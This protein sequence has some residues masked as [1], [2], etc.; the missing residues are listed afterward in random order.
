[1]H[2]FWTKWSLAPAILRQ[3][4][5]RLRQ[6]FQ[7]KGV[8]SLGAL[9]GDALDGDVGGFAHGIYHPL[10]LGRVLD[11]EPVAL[12]IHRVRAATDFERRLR[13]RLERVAD[14]DRD[15][16][17]DLFRRTRRAESIGRIA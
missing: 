13:T 6:A 14:H 2:R 1:M 15:F 12:G 7:R 9:G 8:D 10:F 4:V 11:P 16:V 5:E 3:A 17:D